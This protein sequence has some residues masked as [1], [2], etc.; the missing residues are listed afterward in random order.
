MTAFGEGDWAYSTEHREVARI[1]EVRDIGGHTAYRM[2]LAGPRAACSA[3]ARRR[4]VA[5]FRLVSPLAMSKKSLPGLDSSSQ[6]REER[7]V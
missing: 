6:F 2:W 4:P 3:A 1:V 7:P 5:A